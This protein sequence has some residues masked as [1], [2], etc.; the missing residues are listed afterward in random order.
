MQILFGAAR[1]DS[2]EITV[3][4]RK[5]VNH[6][7]VKAVKLGMS[8][9]SEDRKREGLVLGM[10][11][12]HNMTLAA[13]AKFT[14]HGKLDLQREAGTV[15]K[16]TAKL[17]IATS[18]I[19]K[20]VRFLS[21]GNQQKVVLGKWLLNDSDIIIFDEPTRGIDVGAKAEIYELMSGLA[22]QG[23]AVVMVSSELPEIIRMSNRIAVMSDCVYSL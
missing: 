16:M 5:V 14:N 15:R 10:S 13:L 3:K 2:G 23:K 12:E 9:L 4:G 19:K 18:S 20:Q 17:R 8:F 6:S 21:G 7:P 22:K 11:V 1:P